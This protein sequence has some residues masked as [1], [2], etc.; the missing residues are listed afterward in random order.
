ME[1]IWP[2]FFPV[3]LIVCESWEMNCFVSQM[4]TVLF[5]VIMQHVVVISY[6]LAV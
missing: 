4:R 2:F 6:L 3:N 1:D 5:W